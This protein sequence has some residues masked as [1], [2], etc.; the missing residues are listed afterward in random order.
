MIR[1]LKAGWRV[2]SH[3]TGRNLGTYRTK[4]AALK[5]LRQI[6]FFKHKKG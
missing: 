3:R 4:A 6:A 1:K 2:I 5:R